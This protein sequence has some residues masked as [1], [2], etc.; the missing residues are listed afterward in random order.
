MSLFFKLHEKLYIFLTSLFKKNKK[1]IK[2]YSNGK[3]NSL[4]TKNSKT[5]AT[6][7]IPKNHYP[8]KGPKYDI[9]FSFMFLTM[10]FSFM[11]SSKLLEKMINFP[12]VYINENKEK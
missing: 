9:F 7:K 12:R 10:L 4:K 6:K 11:F 2:F 5:L 3:Q 1:N 8:K